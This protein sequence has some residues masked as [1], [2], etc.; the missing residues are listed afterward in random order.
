MSLH[1]YSSR[2]DI[3]SHEYYRYSE[4]NG[5]TWSEP[6]QILARQ[7]TDRGT[8]QRHARGGYVDLMTDRFFKIRNEALLPNDEIGE[9]MQN[10][11]FHYTLSTDGGRSELY[12]VPF[13]TEGEE[14]D[15]DHPLPNVV[16]GKNC[17]MLGDATCRP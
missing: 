11:T 16:W 6:E 10:K 14:F 8:I 3:L 7:K 5:R 13:I 12:D 2:S 15:A 17:F 1:T 9:F 4:D